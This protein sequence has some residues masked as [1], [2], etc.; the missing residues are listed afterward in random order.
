V[1][2]ASREKWQRRATIDKQVKNSLAPHL[3]NLSDLMPSPKPALISRIRTFTLGALGGACIAVPVTLMLSPLFARFLSFGHSQSVWAVYYTFQNPHCSVY[4]ILITPKDLNKVVKSASIHIHFP[5][6]VHSIIYGTDR[7]LSPGMPP[8]AVGANFRVSDTCDVDAPVLAE[9][10]PTIRVKRTGQEQRNV[11][12]SAE[13][14]D[15]E[16]AFVLI[17][18]AQKASD[19]RLLISGR[20]T[21]SSWNQDL[22]ADVDGIWRNP[23]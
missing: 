17:V 4:T 12:I 1:G 20:A 16:S 2:K 18:G 11:D 5:S 7:I 10:P 6:E 19:P 21:Y 22:P 9:L 13:G 15:K 8:V 23:S 3:R 14:L